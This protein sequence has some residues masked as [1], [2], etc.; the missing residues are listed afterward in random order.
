MTSNRCRVS[1]QRVTQRDHHALGPASSCSV[2]AVERT[3]SSRERSEASISSPSAESNAVP[4]VISKKYAEAT[5][6]SSKIVRNSAGVG[7]VE[8]KTRPATR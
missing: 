6:I 1:E 4:G 7:R 3:E 5:S 2:R 8:G